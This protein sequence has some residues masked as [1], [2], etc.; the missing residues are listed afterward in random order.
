[1]LVDMPFPG[2]PIALGVIFC[3]PAPSY[4][5]ALV[6]QTKTLTQGKIA[7]LSALIRKGQTWEVTEKR[8]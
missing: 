5:S 7:D 2:F 4:E 6:E 8:D 1:M 3:S